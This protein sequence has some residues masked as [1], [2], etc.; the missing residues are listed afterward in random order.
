M[1][2][3]NA[4]AL[5]IKY[6]NLK[7]E[8]FDKSILQKKDNFIKYLSEKEYT[9][10]LNENQ[11]INSILQKNIHEELIKQSYNIILIS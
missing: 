5:A 2:C 4:I 6:N 1:K 10:I 9:Q 7:T 11:I 3:Y 8:D